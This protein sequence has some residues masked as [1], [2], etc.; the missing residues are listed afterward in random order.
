RRDSGREGLR[1]RRADE[2]ADRRRRAAELRP[3]LR[4]RAGGLHAD[5]RGR[6]A[7]PDAA[8]D[9]DAATRRAGRRGGPAG[10]AS[11]RSGVTRE[12]GSPALANSSEFAHDSPKADRHGRGAPREGNPCMTDAAND[13]VA[14]APLDWP[15][16]PWVLAGL[17]GLAGLLMHLVTYGNADVPWQGAVAAALL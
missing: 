9:D 3:H 4:D 12:P 14:T 17:L 2:P 8:A 10:C 13:D 15:L 11:G 6:A 5:G 16:R 7:L 1:R